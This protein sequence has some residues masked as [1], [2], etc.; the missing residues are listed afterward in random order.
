MHLFYFKWILLNSFLLVKYINFREIHQAMLFPATDNHSW[1]S[2]WSVFHAYCKTPHLTFNTFPAQAPS[3]AQGKCPMPLGKWG[4]LREPL[5]RAT[6]LPTNLLETLTAVKDKPFEDWKQASRQYKPSTKPG[7][8]G[9]ASGAPWCQR[10][11]RSGA[12]MTRAQQELELSSL[13]S[14]AQT[15][16]T[17][18]L[19]AA[20][21][22]RGHWTEHCATAKRVVRAYTHTRGQQPCY[23]LLP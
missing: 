17:V 20:A 15:D 12:A 16:F 21:A 3:K 2:N 1:H 18:W 11:S 4:P 19:F 10:L 5:T 14:H 7:R 22:L 9:V 6:M 8:V 23:L 13:H